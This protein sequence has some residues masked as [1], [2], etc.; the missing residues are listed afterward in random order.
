L[1]KT[2][3]NEDDE[4]TIRI[5][6][7]PQSESAIYSVQLQEN[8]SWLLQL[9]SANHYRRQALLRTKMAANATAV[10]YG[11]EQDLCY[12][13]KADRSQTALM[14]RQSREHEKFTFGTSPDSDVFFNDIQIS[15]ARS[16]A[17]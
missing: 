12:Q 8:R 16:V 6:I 4:S 11:D 9:Q 13:E 14:L 1:T 7:L 3:A 17:T 2:V 5:I 10:C 15:Q